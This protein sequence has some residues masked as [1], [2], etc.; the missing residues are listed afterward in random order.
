ML[1]SQLTFPPFYFLYIGSWLIFVLT[2][3]HR[4]L[5]E[6]APDYL[7]QLLVKHTAARSLRSQSIGVASQQ[8]EALGRSTL[9]SLLKTVK[10]F[11]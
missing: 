2:L 10:T 5:N 7:S 3:T 9:W 8:P 4:A 11:V 6:Q 1:G